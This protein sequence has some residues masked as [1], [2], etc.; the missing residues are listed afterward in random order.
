M[1]L[2]YVNLTNQNLAQAHFDSADLSHADFSNANLTGASF[3]HAQGEPA[4]ANFT[5]ADLRGAVAWLPSDDAI[6]H[7]TIRPDGSI[8]GLV[9]MAGE[10]LIVRNNPLGITITLS[11]AFEPASTLQFL[12]AKN[13]TSP[14]GF[15]VGVDPDVNGTLDL[16]FAA[17]VD[18]ITLLGQTFELFD[19]SDV[20][21]SGTFTI[22]SPYAW[23]LS[24]F[25][26]TGEVTLVAIPEPVSQAL[27]VAAFFGMACW[28]GRTD[29]ALTVR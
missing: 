25:Y 1:Q 5:G 15:S 29:I 17:S 10:K 3:V 12:L 18:P 27:L 7:N 6:T 16:E 22:A 19:W 28:R 11:A 20:H 9:L 21:P 23:D 24:R 13:W 2:E 8:Q 4:N 26:T 14:I